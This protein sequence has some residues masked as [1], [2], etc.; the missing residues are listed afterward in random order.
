MKVSQ[1]K[2]KI[3]KMLALNIRVIITAKE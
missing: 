2:F 1:F 3:V